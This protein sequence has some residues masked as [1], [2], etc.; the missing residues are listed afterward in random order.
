VHTSDGQ[1]EVFF[2]QGKIAIFL[3][4]LRGG[5]V[6]RA[7]LTL[8]KGLAERGL[9]I[10]LVLAQ[11]EGPY[12]AQ[13]PPELNI[14]NLQA[15]RVLSS[16][17]NLIH[18]LR[19]E[20]PI[21]LLSAMDH[22]NI[23]ALWA[24][25]LSGVSKRLVVTTHNTLSLSINNSSNR[26][27][28]LMPFLIRHFYPWADEIVAVSKGVADD[29]TLTTGLPRE[30]IQVIY[31]P[32]VT[33]DMLKEAQTPLNHP[34][35]ASGEPPVI[36][37]VGRLTKQKDFS[38]LIRAFSLVQQQYKARLMILGEGEERPLLNRL[39]QELG[40]ENGVIMP[41]FVS[42][43]YAYM[44]RAAVFVLSSAW[45]GLGI[46]LIEALAVGTPV[47]STNCQSGPSEILDNGKYGRLIPVGDIQAMAKAILNTLQ[48]LPPPDFLQNRANEF[49]LE[50]SLRKYFEL[51]K[52]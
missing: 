52:N 12:L 26:T 14:V 11:A 9:N 38:T 7:M 46:V 1:D 15:P 29:L 34:W 33:P 6:E 21:V 25:Y 30:K 16:L 40:L 18:Y 4:S 23:V 19:Q 51:I 27:S 20:R 50:N 32:V 42:N 31:N 8:A 5:G 28:Q 24:R 49:S 45:E 37:A 44:S 17:P 36:L 13:V 43:P 41:G 39:I 2:H 10:D 3:P 35:F 22:A 48:N 47:V